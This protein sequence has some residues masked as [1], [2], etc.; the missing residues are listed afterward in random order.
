MALFLDGQSPTLAW[1]FRR[2][3]TA[4]AGNCFQCNDGTSDAD[5]GFS[6][7]DVDLAAVVAHVAGDTGTAKILYDQSGNARN[8]TRVATSVVRTAGAN[9]TLGG[10][11]AMTLQGDSQSGAAMSNFFAA[12]AGTALCLVSLLSNTTNDATIYNNSSS[13]RDNGGYLGNFFKNTGVGVH[14]AYSYNYQGAQHF[15]NTEQGIELNSVLAMAWRHSGGQVQLNINNGG[16]TQHAS[17]NTDSLAGVLYLGNAAHDGQFLFGE[18]ALFNTA[19]ADADI[20]AWQ[21]EAAG[22]RGLDLAGGYNPSTNRILGESLWAP[23][24]APLSVGRR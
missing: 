20:L 1:G 18:L 15:A 7:N 5:I 3:R 11:L 24:G 12:G 6:G 22:Y 17:G 14:K 23:L 13:W 16:W 9:K 21:V 2:L 10:K 8:S 4:W 19:L